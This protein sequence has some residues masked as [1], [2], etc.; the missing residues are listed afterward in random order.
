M[1]DT[2]EPGKVRCSIDDR[3]LNKAD[4]LFTVS[5]ANNPVMPLLPGLSRS[6]NLC[7]VALGER[8]AA[9]RVA[10]REAVQRRILEHRPHFIGMFNAERLQCHANSRHLIYTVDFHFNTLACQ[11][12]SHSPNEATATMT[13]H[14][15]R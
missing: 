3:C 15:S 4:R 10:S 11:T 12:E 13:A 7:P 9:W 8:F 6:S 14:D 1:S 5:A 2:D